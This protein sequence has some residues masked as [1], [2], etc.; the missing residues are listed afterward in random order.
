[1]IAFSDNHRAV[2]HVFVPQRQTV[3]VEIYKKAQTVQTND[4]WAAC[5]QQNCHSSPALLATFDSLFL[6]QNEM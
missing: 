6:P 2:Q 1:M 3:S 4:S 5:H